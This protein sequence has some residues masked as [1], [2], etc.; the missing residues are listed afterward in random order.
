MT[1]YVIS[2]GALN[3]D[4]SSEQDLFEKMIKGFE[5]A[6]TMLVCYFA[7]PREHWE[8]RFELYQEKCAEIFPQNIIPQ[9][10]LAMPQSFD[11][12][13][14]TADIIYFTGGDDT[15]L[16]HYLREYDLPELFKH[17]VVV[18]SSAGANVLVD[19]FWTCDGRECRNGLG[20]LPVKII[21]HF[22]SAYG[23]EDKRGKI[24]W[25]QARSKLEAYGK[26]LPMYM[27]REGEF[28]TIEL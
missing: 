26:Q 22:A 6:P 17:K 15:L 10:T 19:S 24:H 3:G 2:G 12:Q 21:T 11:E 9:L 16:Y 7:Q 4:L 5:K 27:L 14:R 13:I 8:R 23:E 28:V 20:I 25:E 18:G 1:K